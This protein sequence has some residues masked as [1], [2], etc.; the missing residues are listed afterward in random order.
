MAENREFLHLAGGDRLTIGE[1]DLW[2][3]G[4]YLNPVEAFSQ[5]PDKAGAEDDDQQQDVR[6]DGDQ[7]FGP[8]IGIRLRAGFLFVQSGPGDAYR[9][10]GQRAQHRGD[11]VESGAYGKILHATHRQGHQEH[12]PQPGAHCRSS[13]GYPQHTKSGEK[14]GDAEHHGH[15]RCND[16]SFQPG[17]RPQCFERSAERAEGDGP[18]MPYCRQDHGAERFK[19]DADHDRRDHCH[20]YAKATY[21]L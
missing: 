9:Q 12:R 21:T 4:L 1:G 10:T 6:P 20:R 11:I 15:L 13:T 17:R 16:G 2:N 14:A 18:G 7:I 19:A 5:R 3:G 8:R